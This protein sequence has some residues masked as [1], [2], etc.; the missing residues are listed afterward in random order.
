MT[1]IRRLSDSCLLV[2]TESGTTLFDPGFH[3]FDSGPV[4]LDTI[5]DV[6][7][8]LI[9]HE[10]G[11]HV[12]P[13]FVKWLVDRGDDVAVHSNE[14]VA[15]LLA[16]HDIEVKLADPAGVTHEDVVHE[17]IPNG[18]TPPN[19]SYT[20]DGVFTHPGDSYQ[21]TRTA[22]VMALPLLVPW[23]S[24]TASVDFARRLNP[25]QVVPVHDWYTSAAGRQFIFGMAKGVLAGAGIEVIKLD[26]GDHYTV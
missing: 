15:A 13:E 3:T 20:I 19:R 14:P 11:D 16:P 25:S 12:K 24:M 10:H 21:P 26:W 6:Q 2:T 17:M 1:T 4:D 5:G 8:V 23:G 9:T 22:P 18:T 7:T